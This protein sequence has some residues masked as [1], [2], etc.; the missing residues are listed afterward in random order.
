MT[1]EIRPLAVDDD[2]RS[3][4]FGDEALDLF[5]HRH[6]GQN[7]FRFRR[8][9]APTVG[10]REAH[11][12]LAAQ[13]A[14]DAVAVMYM[15]VTEQMTTQGGGHLKVVMRLAG[16][17]DRRRRGQGRARG[18]ADRQVHRV[19]DGH[20]VH[21]TSDKADG[22]TAGRHSFEVTDFIARLVAHIPDKGQVLQR[23]YGYYANRARG[24][25]RK[26]AQAPEA[27][28]V[29][30]DIDAATSRGLE[31]DL[32]RSYLDFAT[33]S[34]TAV[35]PAR[36]AKPRDKAK[37]ETAV[38]VDMAGMRTEGCLA[39]QEENVDAGGSERSE[40]AL[41]SSSHISLPASRSVCDSGSMFRAPGPL[42]PHGPARS[43][44]GRG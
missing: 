6:A 26:G 44:A 2:R 35:V 23:Y 1:V 36:V 37:V 31:P 15:A 28:P 12:V 10:Y 8:R 29:A 32:N 3:Y 41:S 24:E 19:G 40:W 22:P 17:L 16:G 20:A 18:R 13:V 42:S 30:A 5:F 7:Q 33:H 4:R 21:H 34:G 38:Q 43:A 14:E 27:E 9:P 39:G 25:R 11:S